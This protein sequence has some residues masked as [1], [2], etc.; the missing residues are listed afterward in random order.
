MIVGV[1]GA[2]PPEG[3]L[4]AAALLGIAPAQCLVLEDAPAGV[5]AARAAGMTVFAVTTTHRPH[6][7]ADAHRCFPDPSAAHSSMLD[8]L[9][10]A[11]DTRFE[12]RQATTA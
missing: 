3:Y 11:A 2:L 8:W 10:P 12:P 7:L 5:A 4:R 1:R 6:Q 9:E